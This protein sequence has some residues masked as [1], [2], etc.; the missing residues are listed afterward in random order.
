MSDAYAQITERILE[1]LRAGVVPW[2]RPWRT[3]G[4]PRNLSGRPYRGV[5]ALLLACQD[6]ASPYWLTFRQA[7]VR[8]GHVRRGERG[9][10]VVLWR[11]VERR[12]RAAAEGE[13][14]GDEGRRYLLVRTYTVFNLEQCALPSQTLP[15]PPPEPPAPLAACEQIVAAM[16][17]P[18]RILE[19]GP[20]ALYAPVPD[21][22]LIPHRAD[23]RD[24]PAYYATLF[25][26]LGHATGHPRRLDRPTLSDRCRFGTTNYSR[27]E[28]VA[29]LAGAFLCGQAGIAPAV[30][31]A[32]AAYVRGWLRALGDDPRLVVVAAGQA[33]RAADHILGRAARPA[34]DEA[35]AAA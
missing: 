22:V 30:L 12:E 6:Y 19:G 26:E 29:E 7:R 35:R 13:P 11:P 9:T 18:P 21:I 14:E 32:A 23:F 33:Q 10:H 24:A 1:L 2:Q 5:N 25:H 15:P 27:E 31:D 34:A 20:I 17:D 16:P 4:G 8:G 28:L 3:A